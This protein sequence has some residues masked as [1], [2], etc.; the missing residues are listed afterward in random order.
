MNNRIITTIMQ[1]WHK[2]ESASFSLEAA[3]ILPFCLLFLFSIVLMQQLANYELL[4]QAAGN[5]T[6]QEAQSIVALTASVEH[7][8]INDKLFG[9]VLQKMPSKYAKKALNVKTGV[10][11]ATYLLRR[12]ADLFNE[13]NSAQD[14]LNSRLLSDFQGKVWLHENEHL[15]WYESSYIYKIFLWN[16]RRTSKF[17]V[18]LWNVYPLNDY[19]R[20]SD[21]SDKQQKQTV[22]NE[23]NF[24]RGDILQKKFSANMP[25]TYPTINRYENGVVISIKSIDLT[26]PS[27]V[28]ELY[29]SSRIRN[30]ASQL[31]AFNGYQPQKVNWPAIHP[32]DIK[33][34]KLILIVPENS[35]DKRIKQIESVLNCYP[36]ISFEIIKYEKSYRY[37]SEN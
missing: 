20:S 22:W 2:E 8:K 31:I 30:L 14:S 23:S 21:Q 15:L 29:L 28:D 24:K 36:Q 17:L 6:C 9:T 13:M 4:W 19:S 7:G 26:N 12:Q 3:I 27:L 1:T 37:D 18:P 33:G 25:K 35:N 10:I 32:K 5:V 16:V 34:R 11:A